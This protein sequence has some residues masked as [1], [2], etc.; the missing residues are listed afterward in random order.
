VSRRSGASA[1]A[2]DFIATAQQVYRP[3]TC[4]CRGWPTRGAA[5]QEPPCACTC[6][7][8]WWR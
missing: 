3:I 1:V 5:L 7:S 2:A 8:F 4:S 6:S